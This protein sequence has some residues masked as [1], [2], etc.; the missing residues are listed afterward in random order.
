MSDFKGGLLRALG[1][2]LVVAVL[3]V[4]W[5]LAEASAGVATQTSPARVLPDR[6]ALL[7]PYYQ[8]DE[9][10]ASVTRFHFE[11]QNRALNTQV[12]ALNDVLQTYCQGQGTLQAV[13]MQHQQAT[14]G[15]L[16]LSAVV[17]GPMLAN[18]T[19]RQ[20]DFRPLR[21]NLLNRAIAKQPEGAQQMALVGSPA[22]GFPALDHLLFGNIAQPGSPA[23]AYAV[24]VAQDLAQTFAALDW[25][26]LGMQPDLPLY[27]N[28]LL[29]GVQRLAWEGMQKPWTQHR[30]AGAQ[31][32][33][34]WPHH[35]TG[36]TVAA[37]KTQW[38]SL[39]D[40]LVMQSPFVP[41]SSRQAVPLEAFLRGL[42]KLDLADALLAACAR[43]DAA[44]AIVDAN[45]PDAVMAAARALQALRATL[46]TQV[47]RGLNVSIQFSSSDGD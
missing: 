47:A 12:R 33:V 24:L 26:G 41:D 11:P 10:L 44:M 8:P 15:W 43:V 29:G 32:A 46:E 5:T 34:R 38:Q 31:G 21:E 17:M 25:R 37:W 16:G 20:V 18:N 7:F 1:C 3:L 45:N 22:K 35:D 23:C 27:F 40:L 36:L 6:S 19:V 9:L 2:L 42:G 28:Q 14:L 4:F 13:R 39:E 30:D